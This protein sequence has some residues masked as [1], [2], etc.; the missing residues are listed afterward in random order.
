MNSVELLILNF[1][2]VRR[3]SIKIWKS[4]PKEKLNWRP[5]PNA[6]TC[7]EMIRHVL[8]AEYFYLQVIENRGSVTNP[9]APYDSKDLTT[10]E[11]ELEFAQ[12][13]REA[14][15]NLVKSFSKEDLQAIKIDRS[16]LSDEGYSGYIRPLGDMLLRY[17][18]HEAIHSGQL[19]D[20]MRTAGVECPDIW[21]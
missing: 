11:K 6:M 10:V 15:I 5:D 17:A 13:Y 7:L 16:D 12:P 18:Y 2:E 14:F 9:D 1:E 19:L 20:Y 8:E 21:D 4:I 3:R